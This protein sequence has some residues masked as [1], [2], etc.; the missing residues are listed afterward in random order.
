MPSSSREEGDCLSSPRKEK[1]MT[2]VILFQSSVERAVEVIMA[3]LLERRGSG[4]LVLQGKE[5]DNGRLS[6]FFKEV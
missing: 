2:M 3:Y 4:L 5:Y 6:L 1:S